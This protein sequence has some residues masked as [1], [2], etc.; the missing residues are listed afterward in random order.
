M[1]RPRRRGRDRRRPLDPPPHPRVTDDYERWSYNTAVAAFMELTNELFR[2]A[3]RPRGPASHAR[4][5]RRHLLLLMAPMAPHIT[6]ELWEQRHGDHVHEQPWPV[7]DA[8]KLVVDTVTMVV[9]VNGKVRD[10][11]EVPRASTP[12]RPSAW[13]WP[14]RRC[15]RTWAGWR[16]AR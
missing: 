3:R 13:R 16:R 7:A 1:R 11:I 15:R 12:P 6:A 5:G 10:R 8:A 2:Y 4:R 9:Q 14:A